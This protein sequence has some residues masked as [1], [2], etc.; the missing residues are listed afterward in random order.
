MDFP[1][2]YPADPNE[3]YEVLKTRTRLSTDDVI[4]L[5]LIESSGEAIYA[6]IAK[7]IGNEQARTLLMRNGQEERGHSRRLAKALKL[8]GGPEMAFPELPQN[9]FTRALPDEMSVNGDFLAALECA[10]REG[11]LQYGAWA[12]GEPNQEVA[13]L[14]RQIGTEETRHGER[15]AQVMSLLGWS[16]G[17][18]QAADRSSL[19]IV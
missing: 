6:A 13:R 3:A 16:G 4:M 17:L 8:L 1:A 5:A 18:G 11:E 19:S 9:P 14:Y 7:A 2:G 15:I 10:E 12:D